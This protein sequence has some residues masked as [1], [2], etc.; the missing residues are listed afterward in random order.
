MPVR[1]GGAAAG[2]GGLV[3]SESL[4]ATTN[5]AALSWRAI[6]R[7]P[8]VTEALFAGIGFGLFFVF[9]SRA[10]EVAGH[11]P[12][13]GARAVSVVMFILIGLASST[14]LLPERG[15]R[16]PVVF[17]GVLDAAAVI[18]FVMSTRTGLLSVGAAIAAL[19]PAVTVLLARII[20]KKRIRRQQ[21]VG[22]GLALCA[23]GLLAI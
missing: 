8:G 2:G 11:W 18:F 14:A 3:G 13:V 21:M 15:S 9:I 20:S 7:Q 4:H 17:A 1:S 19:Y 6:V 12:L 16:M 23:V 10:S 22:L 5:S